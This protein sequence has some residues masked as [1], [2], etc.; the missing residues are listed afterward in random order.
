MSTF[1]LVSNDTNAEISATLTRADSG[2]AVDLSDIGHAVYLRFRAAYSTSVLFTLTG[3]EAQ[4]D[5]FAS[6]VVAFDFGS[7][8]TGLAAGDYD[9]E[10]EVKYPDNTRETVYEVVKFIVREDFG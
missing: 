9:G 5:D 8:L 2:L 1:L 10:I 3:L 6:G 7:N 4:P